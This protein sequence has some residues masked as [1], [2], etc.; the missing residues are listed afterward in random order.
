MKNM[1]EVYCL[2]YDLVKFFDRKRKVRSVGRKGILSCVD[3][4]FLTLIKQECGF[5]TNKMLYE[6]VKGT[7]RRDF[8][9]IPSYQQ[10]NNGLSKSL[11]NLAFIIAVLSSI[12]RKKTAKY[13]M[14]DSTPLPLCNNQYRFIAKLAKNYASSGKNLNGWFFGFKL[15]IIANQDMEIES[16]RITGGSTSDITV[17]EGSFIQDIIGWL[18]GDK[19]YISAKKAQELAEKGISLITRTRKNMKK[20]PAKPIHNYLI[21]KRQKIESVFSILK[22][23]LQLINPYARSIQGYLV[24]VL[25]AIATYMF[26]CRSKKS[27]LSQ[28]ILPNLIS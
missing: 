18:V 26:N 5:R 11:Y 6:F 25:S 9:Q 15:H 27:L 23:R 20:Y 7:M 12:T 10:F 3:Y 2:I 1:V 16:I 13:H 4:V 8:P 14:V 28:E 19:G 17:L 21:S 24:G 22:H